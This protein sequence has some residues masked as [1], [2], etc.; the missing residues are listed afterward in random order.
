MNYYPYDLR[1][2]LQSSIQISDECARNIAFN[3]LNSINF[4][5][6]AN[7]IHRDL[8]PENILLTSDCQIKICDFG[9]A[10]AI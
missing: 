5:H 6:S 3:L 7:I 10:T 4:I 8:K 2:I 9:Y 1:T